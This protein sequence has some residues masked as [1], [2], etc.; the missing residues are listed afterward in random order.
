MT[1]VLGT[2]VYPASGSAL[3][4]MDAALHSWTELKGVSL[5]DLQFGGGTG[6]DR[7]P[8]K[9]R[10]VLTT[11]ST[12][13]TGR[14]GPRKPVMSELLQQLAAVAAAE[15]SVYFGF[16]NADIHV[17]QHA[18]DLVSQSGLDAVVF[19]RMDVEAGTGRELGEFYSGQDTIFLNLDFYRRHQSRFRPYV[20]GE[21]PWDVV[22]TSIVLT[23]GNSRLVN[24]GAFTTHVA[25]ETIWVDSPFGEHAWR[26]ARLDWAYM[27]RWYRFY[28]A[29]KAL[30]ERGG[31]PVR[32]DQ[33][34]D[35]A[36][37]RPLTVDE[38]ARTMY[39]VLK[40]RVF[41][42]HLS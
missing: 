11:D 4:R 35:E 30:R 41:A 33:F 23:H 27:A 34:L 37:R 6:S 15:G 21:M 32:E 3:S 9:S 26:L 40:D 10:H 39:R 31:D 22:Y 19:T 20:V 5:V 8:F 2:H 14:E 13:I 18:I 16:S 1:V 24:R 42:R 12:T 28:Y 17:S 7:S 25:H 29:V 38:R 36:F